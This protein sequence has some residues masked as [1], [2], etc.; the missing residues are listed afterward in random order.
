MCVPRG[1]VQQVAYDSFSGMGISPR[2]GDAHVYA[3]ERDHRYS[4]LPAVKGSM[5]RA[6][7]VTRGVTVR[8]TGRNAHVLGDFARRAVWMLLKRVVTY[9]SCPLT[10][11]CQSAIGLLRV[12]VE[13]R[14]WF[15]SARVVLERE[16]GSRARGRACS[17][18]RSGT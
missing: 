8:G 12:V 13:R 16:G 2:P 17:G 3:R 4:L 14:R 1:N 9:G 6:T 15:R 10:T 5:E 18:R 7:L 11:Y